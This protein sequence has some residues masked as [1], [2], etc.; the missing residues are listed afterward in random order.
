MSVRCCSTINGRPISSD[1]FQFSLGRNCQNHCLANKQNQLTTLL[2]SFTYEGGVQFH[3]EKVIK[4]AQIQ[5]S[6]VLS[7]G[8]LK[9]QAAFTQ[10]L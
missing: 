6:A 2:P 9:F 1:H 8:G 5:W 3:V 4:I 7:R 10:K